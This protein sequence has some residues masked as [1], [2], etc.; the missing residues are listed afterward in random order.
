MASTEQ[1]LYEVRDGAAWIKLNRP[2]KRN[3]LSAMLIT[4]VYDHIQA[5]NE[6]DDARCIVITGNGP[7]FC[8]G[9]DLKDDRGLPEGRAKRSPIRT[10]WPPFRTTRSR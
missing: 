8:S 3:A 5:A 1:T 2:E 7:G 10:C 4:E 9:A 6:D